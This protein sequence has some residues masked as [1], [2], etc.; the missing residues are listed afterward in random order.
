MES[1]LELYRDARERALP[2]ELVEQ[3][4]KRGGRPKASVVLRVRNAEDVETFRRRN[5]PIFFLSPEKV[6]S[7]GYPMTF[8]PRVALPRAMMGQVVSELR[9]L[10]VK[11]T[12]TVRL[13]RVETLVG[14][15]LRVDRLAARALVERNLSKVNG[16]ELYR[17]V[18]NEGL[19][20]E[21]TKVR[22]QDYAKD[23]PVVGS[24]L[25]RKDLEW[26]LGNNPRRS[27][28]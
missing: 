22:L 28:P 19:E 12:E 4:R 10:P 14:L 8:E 21:A 2:T 17:M 25:P 15:M 24:A 16:S 5:V 20:R 27:R 1:R 18:V 9:V 7:A 6:S 13:D 3:V 26:A 11:N 23:V